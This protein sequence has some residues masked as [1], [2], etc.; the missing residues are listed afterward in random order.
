MTLTSCF[1]VAI[2]VEESCYLSADKGLTN[3]GILA[4][5]PAVTEQIA[6]ALAVA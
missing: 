1:I 2:M 5:P 3:K 4:Q 6:Q